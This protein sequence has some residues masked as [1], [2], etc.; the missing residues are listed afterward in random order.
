VAVVKLMT[1]H[2]KLM[3]IANPLL[4][5]LSRMR[6]SRPMRLI[7]QRAKLHA[8][9]FLPERCRKL[10]AAALALAKAPALLLTRGLRLTFN[11]LTGGIVIF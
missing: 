9:S 10:N 11:G 5:V 4:C 2:L 1:P 6:R 8:A 7:P 3:V